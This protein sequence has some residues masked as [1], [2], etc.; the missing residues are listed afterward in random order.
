MSLFYTFLSLFD[1]NFRFVKLFNKNN[2]SD[3]YIK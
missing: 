3:L 1:V 2:V